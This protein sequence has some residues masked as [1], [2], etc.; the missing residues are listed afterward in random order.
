MIYLSKKAIKMIRTTHLK[1]LLIILW[2]YCIKFWCL[3]HAK[4]MSDTSYF[5]ISVGNLWTYQNSDKTMT[6]TETVVE[7]KLIRGKLYYSL[8]LYGSG[9]NFWIRTDQ[10]KV[11]MLDIRSYTDTTEQM[12]YDFSA[13]VGESWTVNVAEGS[14]EYGGEITVIS[15]SDSLYTP[16]GTFRNCIHLQRSVPCCDAGRIDEWFAPGIG[17]VLYYEIF[18]WGMDGFSLTD[19]NITISPIIRHDPK[20]TETF[21]LSQNYPNPFNAE[22]TI[23]YQLF[24]DEQVCLSIY[25]VQGILIRGLINKKQQRGLYQIIWGGKDNLGLNVVSGIYFLRLQTTNQL[26]TIKMILLQ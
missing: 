14:C 11:Y 22:T 25:D 23:S 19:F 16:K 24:D 4:V 21:Y 15:K 12:I 17:N 26:K 7:A 2:I 10:N 6:Q 20:M 18:I 5:P 1:V 13:N 9:P 3:T 8:A